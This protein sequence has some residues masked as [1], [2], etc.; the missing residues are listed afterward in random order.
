MRA[1]DRQIYLTLATEFYSTD[2]VSHGV[3]QAVFER[4]F[5]EITRPGGTV[6]GYLF[7]SEGEVAGY[8]LTSRMFSPEVGGIVL[9]LEEVYLRP[10]YRGR[11]LGGEFFRMVKAMDGICRLRLEVMPGNERA[12]ALYRRQGFAPLE[13]EQMFLD[14][15]P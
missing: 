8:A 7:V 3:P 9:W 13:Y 1:D 5:A 10:A 12:K 15:E 14:R 2:A 4:T 11:G 6:T